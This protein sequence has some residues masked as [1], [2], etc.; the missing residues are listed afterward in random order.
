MAGAQSHPLYWPAVRNAG[1]SLL[2]GRI[3]YGEKILESFVPEKPSD[4]Y[5]RNRLS[6]GAFL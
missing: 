1:V 5:D 2:D 6:G 3:A 4:P